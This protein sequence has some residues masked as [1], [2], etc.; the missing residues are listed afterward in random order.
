MS[1]FCK[2]FINLPLLGI[3][4]LK[5]EPSSDTIWVSMLTEVSSFFENMFEFDPLTLSSVLLYKKLDPF[6]AFFL[7][8]F[9]NIFLESFGGVSVIVGMDILSI[10]LAVDSFY[11]LMDYIFFVIFW[12]WRVILF[13]KDWK[14]IF[15]FSLNAKVSLF[16]SNSGFW[17]TVVFLIIYWRMVSLL[18]FGPYFYSKICNAFDRF[19][20]VNGFATF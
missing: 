11:D 4:L 7:M 20:W 15:Y 12:F 19:P 1:S 13:F 2:N 14:Y 9:L 5:V 3:L 16:I 17:L 8:L 6:L 10:F 18:D